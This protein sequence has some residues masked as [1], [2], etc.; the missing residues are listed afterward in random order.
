MQRRVGDQTA[1]LGATLNRDGSL[2]RW[3]LTGTYDHEENRTISDRGLDLSAYRAAV[4]AGDPAADP[5]L[6]LAPQFL[7]SRPADQAQILSDVA[8]ADWSLNG[9]PIRLP[10]GKVSTTLKVG[11]AS[12]RL[13]SNSE[14]GLV[15]GQARVNRTLA[16]GQFSLNIPLNS[17]S[18][19]F[20]GSIG[21]LSANGDVAV[22]RF[23]DFGT[24][25]SLGYGVNWSPE[26]K[27][28]VI[29]SYRDEQVA[30]T[31]QQLGNPQLTT[32]FAPLFDYVR[33]E[34]VLV[35]RISGGN[36]DLRKA[37]ART[38]RLGLS[39]QPSSDPDITLSLDYSRVRTSGAI[40]P[41]PGITAAA[42]N[43][44]PDRFT[45][46]AG[47]TLTSVD[48]RP[49]NIAQIDDDQLR[50][51]INFRKRLK[52][53]QAQVDAM[54]AAYARRSSNGRLGN[55][56][57]RA[58]GSAGR[59]A[60]RGAGAYGGGR[61][62]L[63]IYHTWHIRNTAVLSAGT[64]P[65]DLL[66]GGT[67]GG[68]SGQPRHEVELQTAYTQSGIG[69]RITGDWQSATRVSGT[70]G[71]ASGDLHFSDLATF[72]LRLFANLGQMPAIVS[73]ASWARGM[74]ISLGVNNMFNT[75]QS[76]TD[77]NGQTPPA[78]L[79]GYIDPLGRTLRL[80]I[81]KLIF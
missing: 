28:S 10:A 70:P 47:G 52:I 69:V 65:I 11:L 19:R 55:D 76:V 73:S 18:S 60:G 48:F 67:L 39:M 68:G 54:R 57:A 5:A 58:G 2:W 20:L 43:A 50:W 21:E 29:L 26:Q 22:E 38:W 3:T 32:P 15:R 7:I 33:G 9:A 37:D 81:R 40:M 8:T 14:R 44:F 72:N 36:P 42:Q 17:S 74:R 78:Y 13:K 45:R 27:V 6:V 4:A 53:S 75:R 66:G 71:L 1:H 35:N 41:L 56:A 49:V 46:D 80:T 12:N 24:L 59:F 25:R 79:P 51:G 64:P 31:M 62:G 30:P 16:D 77:K 61:L 63:A 34:S 23:S